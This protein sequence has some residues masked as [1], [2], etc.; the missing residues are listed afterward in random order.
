MYMRL[1]FQNRI[2]ILAICLTCI[3]RCEETSMNDIVAG[4][5]F[6]CRSICMHKL[7]SDKLTDGHRRIYWLTCFASITRTT[8]KM[9]CLAK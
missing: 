5:S 2:F 8:L 1:E 4:M 6:I 7:V 3:N 9:F